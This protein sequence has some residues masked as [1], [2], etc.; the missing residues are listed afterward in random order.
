[1]PLDEGDSRDFKKLIEAG[2]PDQHR[3]TTLV[4]KTIG[5]NRQLTWKDALQEYGLI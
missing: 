1:M 3:L 4:K 5:T 2:L